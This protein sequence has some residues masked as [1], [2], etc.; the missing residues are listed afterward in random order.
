MCLSYGNDPGYHKYALSLSIYEETRNLEF[1]KMKIV[2]RVSS[3]L[4]E[5]HI[6]IGKITRPVMS[7]VSLSKRRTISNLSSVIHFVYINFQK[8]FQKWQ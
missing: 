2:K 4:I 7:N 8:S 6:T 1:K 3:Y 5:A